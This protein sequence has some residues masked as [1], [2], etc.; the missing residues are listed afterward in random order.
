MMTLIESGDDKIEIC[1]DYVAN[2]R[3][4]KDE[5]CSNHDYD[6]D[7]M[8]CNDDDDDVDDAQYGNDGDNHDDAD[9]GNGYK[10]GNKNASII[11][12]LNLRYKQ[13]RVEDVTC[14]IT[15]G[16]YNIVQL[17]QT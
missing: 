7:V 6:I 15:I 17:I 14:I 10:Y 12:R 9:Q 13:K 16:R 11:N 8:D 3:N 2:Y 5:D 1:D 4:R